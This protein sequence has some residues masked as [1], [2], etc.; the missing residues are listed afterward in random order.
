M[1]RLLVIAIALVAACP[2]RRD[3]E[4]GVHACL[5]DHAGVAARFEPV[6]RAMCA[7][8]EG[9]AV[10]GAALAIV[11][12]GEVVLSVAHG[13]RCAH[14]REPVQ[15]DT[16]FRIG[17]VTKVFTAATAVSLAAA[18]EVDL[19]APVRG[20]GG[21]FAGAPAHVSV[22]AL[23]DHRAGVGERMP[24]AERAKLAGD[25]L[26]ADLLGAIDPSASEPRY[27]SAGYALAAVALER[28]SA[29]P[30][31]NALRTRVTD[32]LGLRVATSTDA[33][34]AELAA[35]GHLR[36]GASWRAYDV[37][38]DFAQLAHDAQWS[39]PAGG[40]IVSAP[41][42]ARFGDA[43]A[44]GRDHPGLVRLRALIDAAPDGYALGLR[45]R[46]LPGGEPWWHHR[47]D[48]GDFVA[49]LHV[50]PHRGFAVAVVANAPASLR[51]TVL[52]ALAATGVQARFDAGD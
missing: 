40:L 7:E 10:P 8:I 42:L 39:A 41:E 46:T 34:I 51:A 37:V 6:V 35:C 47:G 49:E 17:S 29:E 20:L 19:D 11:E 23:L 30:W 24:T 9:H 28:A 22:R 50:L 26:V 32:P 48:T 31:P 25:A 1:R 15:T 33:G 12:H 52:A 21:A 27:S 44:H 18:G 2:A 36:E 5:R 14:A 43:L 3:D 13:R 45:K 4:T 16:P 38:E